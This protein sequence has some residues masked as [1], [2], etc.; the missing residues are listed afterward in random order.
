MAYVWFV[1]YL[2]G[3]VHGQCLTLAMD[4]SAD[5]WQSTVMDFCFIFALN[6]NLFR[7]KQRYDEW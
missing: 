5:T 3:G 2:V 4:Q 6:K 7:T 1:S